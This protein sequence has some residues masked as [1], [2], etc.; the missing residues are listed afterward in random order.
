MAA[1][2]LYA[3]MV[4]FIPALWPGYSSFSQTISE[5]SAVGA[6]TRA[7]WVITGTL[8][9][10]LSILFADSIRGAAHHDARL[11]MVGN[12]AL[13]SALLGLAWP[14]MHSRAVLAAGGG[15]LSDSLHLVWSA[16]T[17]L[18]MFGQMG[19]AAAA[20]GARFRLYSIATAIGLLVFGVLTFEGAPGVAANL[21]T[22]WLGVWERLNVLGFML[23]QAVLAVTLMRG[24]PPAR[25]ATA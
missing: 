4:T 1:A 3:G 8:W 10:V 13:V 19:F 5:L 6:P 14:P 2:I 24:R 23:W 17:V 15:T 12:L 9:A 16:V 21:P 11:R 18:L 7:V 25:Y 22:P 20:L